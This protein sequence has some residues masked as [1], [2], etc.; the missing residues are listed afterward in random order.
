MGRGDGLKFLLE[1]IDS[2]HE[3]SGEKEY[4]FRL[5]ITM[6]FIDYSSFNL[7]VLATFV[8]LNLVE[9][10]EKRIFSK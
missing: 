9:H 1:F 2:E 5:A 10:L 8:P 3:T 6:P 4:T 7:A